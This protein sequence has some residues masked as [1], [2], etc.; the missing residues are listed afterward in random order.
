MSST[1]DISVRKEYK[2]TLSSVSHN[3]TAIATFKSPFHAT[4]FSVVLRS[5]SVQ[6]IQPFFDV[7]RR[8]S[9]IILN[10]LDFIDDLEK[11]L[12][13]MLPRNVQN[14]KAKGFGYLPPKIFREVLKHIS[15]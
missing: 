14:Q 5:F 7:M 2:F 10:S 13:E 4:V 9:D 8:D 15:Q 6:G 11:I 3:D 1:F 12:P